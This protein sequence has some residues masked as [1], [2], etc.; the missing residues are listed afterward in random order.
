MLCEVGMA[1]MVAYWVKVTVG[2]KGTILATNVVAKI[3]QKQ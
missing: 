3:H 2:Q 1:E